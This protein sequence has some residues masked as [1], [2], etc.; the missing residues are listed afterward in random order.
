MTVLVHPYAHT[1]IRTYAHAYV[2]LVLVASTAVLLARVLPW[3]SSSISDL[4]YKVASLLLSARYVAVTLLPWSVY[5]RDNLRIQVDLVHKP[6]CIR[7]QI[8]C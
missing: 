6:V 2:L 8:D 7:S 4:K 3:R 1:H 5:V